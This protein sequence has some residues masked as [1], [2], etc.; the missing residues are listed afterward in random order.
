MIWLKCLIRGD[1]F[2]GVLVGQDHLVGFYTTQFV[3][4]DSA[5]NAELQAL[6]LLKA[7]ES[8]QFSE[9]VRSASTATIHFEEI[10]EVGESEV[11]DQ[12]PGLSIFPMNE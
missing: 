4:A 9:E 12:Q 7:H 1:N 3:Q 8:L 5:E 11:N 10:V 6:Q 2:P